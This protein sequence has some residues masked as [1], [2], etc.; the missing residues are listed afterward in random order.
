VYTGRVEVKLLEPS[1]L[2]PLESAELSTPP[3][4]EV[5]GT[6]Y[7]SLPNDE[8]EVEFPPGVVPVEVTNVEGTGDVAE[9]VSS[10]V[11]C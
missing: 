1:E 10:P 5:V 6:E 9:L 8:L 2:L 4:L 11:N 7:S 3:S